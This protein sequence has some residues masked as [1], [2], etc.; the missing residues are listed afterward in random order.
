MA[1]SD[2]I[3]TAPALLQAYR[4]T[5]YIVHAAPNFVLHIDQP[6]PALAAYYARRRI[7]ASCVITAWNP[8]SQPLG[9]AENRVR[10]ARLEQALQQAGWHWLRTVAAHPRNGWPAEVGCFVQEMCAGTAIEWGRHF[11]QNA[12]VCCGPDATARLVLLR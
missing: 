3:V 9:D 1:P 2:R 10:Q 7:S 5:D 6:C 12:I 11:E 4:E 8:H